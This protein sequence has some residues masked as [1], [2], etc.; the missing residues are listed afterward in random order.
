MHYSIYDGRASWYFPVGIEIVAFLL[1]PMRYWIAIILGYALGA[2]VYLHHYDG[3]PYSNIFK[4]TLY[5]FIDRCLPIAGIVYLK[6]K[7]LELRLDKVKSAVYILMAALTYRVI[8]F[9]EYYFL[10]SEFLYGEFASDKLFELF[11]LHIVTGFVAIFI[12]LVLVFTLDYFNQYIKMIHRNERIQMF[13]QLLLVILAFILLYFYD[14]NTLY[15]LNMLVVIP[16]VWFSYRFG[17]IGIMLFANCMNLIILI[18]AFGPASDKVIID[19]QP[20]II[21]YNLVAILLGAMTNEYNNIRKKLISTNVEITNQ[22]RELTSLNNNNQ[23]LSK[24]LVSLQEVERKSIAS[25]LHDEIGQNITALKIALNLVK[26]DSTSIQQEAI[27]YMESSS[28]SLNNSV[29]SMLNWLSPTILEDKG[30]QG[31]IE[32]QYFE[33]K[34][35]KVKIDY[36]AKVLGDISKLPNSLNIAIFRIIQEAVTNSMKHSKAKKFVLE[37]ERFQE[38]IKITIADDGVGCSLQVADSFTQGG[39]GLAGIKDRVYSF[40]G[41]IEIK[42]SS[43]FSFKIIFPLVPS[44]N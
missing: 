10:E 13:L 35:K 31:V 37:V 8:R 34:L 44:E 28:K 36:H 2:T 22:N 19:V 20:Y 4:E 29:Y 6:F 9:L 24:R 7:K 27:D 26:K 15:I 41:D 30:L 39:F 12:I 32:S 18:Y 25:A 43:G 1:M 21:S 42:S 33:D 23:K 40:G 38:C 16:L 11:L 5:A 17:W 3:L 14:R